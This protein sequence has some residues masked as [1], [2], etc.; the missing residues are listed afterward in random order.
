MPAGE[1]TVD[2]ILPTHAGERW[3]A[4]AI[5]SVLCQTHPCWRLMVVDDCSPD[6]TAE[7]VNDWLSE[8]GLSPAR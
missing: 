1:L 2:V 3:V 5:E 8:I 4:E 6:A 7:R